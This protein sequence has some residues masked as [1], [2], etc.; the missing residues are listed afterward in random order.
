MSTISPHADMTTLADVAKMAGVSKMTVS[1]V[2]NDS[3]PVA[4]ATR[5]K[6]LA[7]AEAIHYSPNGLLGQ[8]RRGAS[9]ASTGNLGLLLPSDN[10]LSFAS[11]PYSARLF[12]GLQLE[13]RQQHHHLLV[14]PADGGDRAYLPEAVMERRVDG[15]L[16]TQFID[17][18]LFARI[19][20]VMPVV[21]VNIHLEGEGIPAILPA[22]ASGVRQALDHL[23]ELG[24][25]RIVFFHIADF[26]HISDPRWIH[27]HHHE[28]R[29]EAFR[30]LTTSGSCPMPEA[31]F[32]TLPVRT[33]SLEDT[34]CDCLAAWRAAGAMPT[35]ILCAADVFAI[36]FL[37]AA[38]RLGLRVPEDLSLIGFDDTEACE[39]VRPQ[40]TSVRQ[41]L[42]EMGAAAVQTLVRRIRE[43]GGE[44][45][46]QTFDVRLVRRRSCAARG[47]ARP[48]RRIRSR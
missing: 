22:E 16:A 47:V 7:A 40:I 43:P 14:V 10:H 15:M 38:N 5:R 35:A 36:A 29:A 2:L 12:S 34:A 42:E 3:G 32:E 25:S 48:S 30:K 21:L 13:A 18:A 17:P 11:D 4:E 20:G 46:E 19:H 1:R 28:V 8:L 39:L 33:K 24:H 45:L 27:R 44:P 37:H 6:V 9:T 41:P 26:Q 31:R 23:R